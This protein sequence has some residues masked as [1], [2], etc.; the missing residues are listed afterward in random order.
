M[1]AARCLRFGFAFIACTGCTGDDTNPALPATPDA[2]FPDSA[3]DAPV[4]TDDAAP[5]PLPVSAIRIANWSPDSPAVDMCLS[6]HGADA[7]MP[8]LLL[9][10]GDAIEAGPGTLAYPGVSAYFFVPPGQYDVRAVVAGA[11]DCAAGVAPDLTTLPAVAIGDFATLALIGSA[12]ASGGA[13]ALAIV[14]F[15]DDG[16]TPTKKVALRFINAA[17]AA[18]AFDLGLGA[19]TKF[20]PVFSDVVFGAVGQGTDAGAVDG[21]I[22][23][24]SRGYATISPLAGGTL[25]A[26]AFGTTDDAIVAQGVNVAA[27]AVVT[28]TLLQAAQGLSDGGPA[29]EILECLDNAGTVGLTGV[30]FTFLP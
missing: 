9:T 13:P 23:V 16:P 10:E 26:R 2:S 11:N 17:G 8:P 21:G 30:C 5:P 14:G 28:T 12:H 29:F 25:S 24:D 6:P 3:P 19:A 7:F 22:V 18:S 1:R 4:P 27:G 20:L 15:R